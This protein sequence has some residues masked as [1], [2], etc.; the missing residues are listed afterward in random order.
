MDNPDLNNYE[1]EE[2][3]DDV[4]LIE[5]HRKLGEMKNERKKAESDSKLLNNRLNLL[6][7]EEE[8]VNQF[9]IGLEK[10]GLYSK[11]DK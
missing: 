2:I 4:Y 11:E 8:K 3:D 9:K 5:L 7:N 1:T 10:S 6:K